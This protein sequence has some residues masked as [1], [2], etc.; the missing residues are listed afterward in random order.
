MKRVMILAVLLVAL[1]VA[2]SSTFA[3]M[4]GPRVPPIGTEGPDVRARVDPKG[5]EGPDVRQVHG[6][7]VPG[8]EGPDIR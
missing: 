4:E 6:P 3:Q 5:V 7:R 1:G 2:A 8:P